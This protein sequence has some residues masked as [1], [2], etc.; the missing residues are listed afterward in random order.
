MKGW[1]VFFWVLAAVLAVVGWSRLNWD[2][3]VLNTLPLTQPAV[4]GLQLQ[5]QYFGQ[6]D[7][8]ILR[9]RTS[10]EDETTDVARALAAELRRHTSLVAAVWWQPPLEE[11]ASALAALVAEAW[12]NAPPGRVERLRAELLP[13]QL[14][15]TLETARQRLG[16]SLSPGE[17][18][19]LSYD[20]L[21]LTRILSG[22][23]LLP[24]EDAG[25]TPG[26][27]TA[28][29]RSRFLWV[30]PQPKLKGYRECQAWLEEV[31]VVVNHWQSSNGTPNNLQIGFTGR[32]AFMAEIGGGM[33]QDM[34]F[35][36]LGTLALIGGLFYLAHRRWRPLMWLMVL[37]VLNFVLT[38]GLGALWLG[39]IN[40]VSIGFAAIL[41]GLAADY[42]M[43]LFQEACAHPGLTANEIQRRARAGIYGSALTTAGAFLLL[44]FSTLPGLGQL[45]VLVAVGILLAA[46]L[47]L[48]WYLPP[49]QKVWAAES[50]RPDCAALSTLSTPVWMRCLRW[51]SCLLVAGCV[52]VLMLL[53]PPL[54]EPSASA[55]RP[56]NSEGYAVWEEFKQ[57]TSTGQEPLYVIIHAGSAMDLYESAK[58]L[59]ERCETLSAQGLLHSANIPSELVMDAPWRQV[60]AGNL[61]EVLQRKDQWMHAVLQAGFTTNALALTQLIVEHWTQAG[62]GKAAA[63]P[64]E[65]QWLR[66][67]CY[68]SADGKRVLLG[69]LHPVASPEVIIERLSQP[70]GLPVEIY[71]T[72]WEWVGR[73]L[74]RMMLRELPWLL[75]A[76]GGVVVLALWVALRSWREVLLS[77]G[78]LAVSVLLLLGC[79]RL[80]GWQWHLMNLMALPLMLGLGV[81]YCLH[82][83]LGLRRH[84]GDWAATHQ[85]VGRALLLAGATT[86]AALGSL[87]MSTNAGLAGLGLTTAAGVVACLI[88][89]LLFLPAW[90]TA[91]R[92]T[93]TATGGGRGLDS[94]TASF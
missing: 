93:K 44:N 89:S 10:T 70:L 30:R 23:S 7:D 16:T 36:A 40:V 69:I 75:A 61:R 43:V 33:E 1:R 65:A 21:G 78:V 5:Q 20:P 60:N 71:I 82:L 85:A 4:R 47:M 48:Q 46:V 18:A 42:A 3:E 28:D 84:Q 88:S 37:L 39:A 80:A 13:A 35:P 38:L 73:T 91:T 77:L 92:K 15:A 24:T 68:A 27:Q 29:G 63:L 72:N 59:R 51:L 22:S 41:M 11:N 32:P 12:L 86:A 94:P 54:L 34:S 19:R 55:L 79:M 6:T 45:G 2:V 26:F 81:D 90:E 57:S 66:D 25:Y 56:R 76:I 9:V 58:V 31:R 87:A 67:R 62:E 52:A 8:L 64:P 74:A 49:L 83:L 14:Q 53:G 17:L 50:A